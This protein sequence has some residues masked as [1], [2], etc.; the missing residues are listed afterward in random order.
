LSGLGGSTVTSTYVPASS[1]VTESASV[2]F[3]A[4]TGGQTIIIE[5]VVLTAPSGGLTAAEV[6]GQ[7]ASLSAGGTPTGIVVGN[8][9]S[10]HTAGTASGAVVAFTAVAYSTTTALTG[11]GTGTAPSVAHVA[12]NATSTY[13][14]DTVTFSALTSGQTTIFD[15]VTIT[16]PAG[17][18]TGTEVAAFFSGKAA[19]AAAGDIVS[20]SLT[21][22][23]Y[24]T[25]AASGSTVVFTY[26]TAN[27]ND[28][29]DLANTGTGSAA[30]TVTQG[31]A[32]AAASGNFITNTTS[33]TD[34]ATLLNAANTAL[35]G[36]AKYYFGVTGGDGYLVVDSDGNGYTDVIQLTGVTTLAPADIVA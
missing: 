5:S 34:L 32:T 26:G 25:G 4:L 16:A 13:T 3:S 6:A 29:S 8:L 36:T 27:T 23:G 11:A 7:F 21:A 2:V 18:L 35:D 28:A 33:V 10:T 1:N 9:A 30:V 17:G 24:S 22:S 19:S 31:S 20:G 14:V 12:G 15:G